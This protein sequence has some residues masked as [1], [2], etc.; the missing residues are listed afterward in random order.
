[1]PKKNIPPPDTDLECIQR[2]EKRVARL[3]RAL[4]QA[5]VAINRWGSRAGTFVELQTLQNDIDK[6]T[7]ALTSDE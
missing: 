3:E 2:L 7:E 1:M 5:I 6:A 4:S